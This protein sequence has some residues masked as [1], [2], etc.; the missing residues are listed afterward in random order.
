MKC[1][2]VLI[3]PPSVW[4][5]VYPSITQFC[6]KV[7]SRTYVKGTGRKVSPSKI[8]KGQ[9]GEDKCLERD[10]TAWNKLLYERSQKAQFDSRQGETNNTIFPW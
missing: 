10:W 2:F 3:T 5:T 7:S 9:K 1:L 8:Q 6:L 4:E